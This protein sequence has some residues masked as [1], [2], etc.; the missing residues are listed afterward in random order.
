MWLELRYSSNLL[1]LFSLFLIGEISW[2][3]VTN[4]AKFENHLPW[5]TL[6]GADNCFHLICL[7]LRVCLFPAPET[8]HHFTLT[9]LPRLLLSPPPLENY[10][11]LSNFLAISQSDRAKEYDKSNSH[12]YHRFSI[13]WVLNT[14][15]SWDSVREREEVCSFRQKLKL[16]MR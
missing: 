12:S 16:S 10:T 13:L 7:I 9:F 5:I 8:R 14:S 15:L 6:D 4:T 1:Y 3:K 11:S 2:N